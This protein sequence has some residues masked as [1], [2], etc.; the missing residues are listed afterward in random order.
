MAIRHIKTLYL[1][2]EFEE[3]IQRIRDELFPDLANIRESEES[4]WDEDTSPDDWMRPL[5]ELL[6]SMGD[7]FQDE[8][9]IVDLIDDQLSS[10][11]SWVVE[12]THYEYETEERL[13]GR[14]ELPIAPTGGRSI[15]DDI[16]A[17]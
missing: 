3:L 5:T 11:E 10:I 7:Y 9:E 6:N 12:H 8:Q 17:D 16:N 14:V 13:I 2:D 4:S 15:F 1:E